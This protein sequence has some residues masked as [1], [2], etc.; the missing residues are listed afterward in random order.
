MKEVLT[1]R[2]SSEARLAD[3]LSS[4]GREG[5]REKATHAVWDFGAAGLGA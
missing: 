1:D 5:E 3:G 4:Y 2:H